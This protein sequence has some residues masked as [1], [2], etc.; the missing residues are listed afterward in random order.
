MDR[1]IT[2]RAAG[3]LS[4]D[5]LVLLQKKVADKFWAVPGGRIEVGESSEQ[6]LLREIKEEMD[7]EPRGSNL[8]CILE[9]QFEHGGESYHQ[10]GFYYL[11]PAVE[12]RERYPYPPGDEFRICEPDL[13]FC[14]VLQSGLEEIDIRPSV[15]TDLLREPPPALIHKAHGFAEHGGILG[16]M[17]RSPLVGA[18]LNLARSHEAGRKLEL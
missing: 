5:G 1:S 11:I 8:I 9:H 3:I 4:T 17:R 13:I 7:W 6:A 2:G 14:W 10:H 15:L 12:L 16:A 18:N